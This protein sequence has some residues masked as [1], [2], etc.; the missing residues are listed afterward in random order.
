MR[1]TFAGLVVLALA[2]TVAATA[3]GRTT[4]TTAI[5]GCA[6]GSL[7]LLKSGQLTLGTDNPA[8]PPWWGG[9]PKNPWKT[10]YPYSGKGY[11]SA[12]AYE[13]ARRLGF[14]RSEVTWNA[15]PFLKSFA[16]GKKPFDFYLAQVSVKPVRAKAVTFSRSYYE[17]NQ[18]VVALKGT[19]IAKVK[20]VA[21]LKPYSFGVP[22]GTTSYDYVVKY[23]KPKDKPK[24]YDTLN[25]AVTALK[26]RQIQGL[27][28]DFPSTGYITGVQVPNSTV[29]G[30]LPTRG[31]QEHFGLVFAKGNPLVGCV[32]KAIAAMSRDGTLKRFEKRWLTASGPVLR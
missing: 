24:V 31:E 20:T 19:P 7:N 6:K 25:D 4:S 27:V 11:E 16:P 2:L 22:L 1:K 15:V 26:N 29:V 5:P 10:S 12:V 30:R 14:A 17:V 21:G 23:I 3:T 32:N 9:T 8:F 28:V 13:I 18:A